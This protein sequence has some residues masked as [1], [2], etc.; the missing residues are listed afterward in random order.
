MHQTLRKSAGE[1]RAIL[2]D[3]STALKHPSS[4]EKPAVGSPSIKHL[5]HALQVALMKSGQL[6]NRSYERKTP[7]WPVRGE[8]IDVLGYGVEKVVYRVSGAENTPDNVVSVFHFASMK[9]E[10]GQVI[11]EKRATYDTYKS[12]FGDLVLPTSFVIIDNPWGDGAKPAY[13]QPF[14]KDAKKFSGMSRAELAGLAEADPQ[15][16]ANLGQLT[17]GYS[18]MMED[19]MRP[20]FSSSNLL[21]SGSDIVIFDTGLIHEADKINSVIEASANYRIIESL[22]SPHEAN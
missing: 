12:Y 13:I 14:I 4:A 8:S 16:A 18:R 9:K 7:K 2:A 6:A 10:P 19:G 21:V 1:A 11:R 15:F 22:T 3:G 5:M 20:D 17:G